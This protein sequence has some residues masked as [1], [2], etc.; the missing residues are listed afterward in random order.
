MAFVPKL[1]KA[2]RA[3]VINCTDIF[4]VR[5]IN[6]ICIFV[7]RRVAKI[8]TGTSFGIKFGGALKRFAGNVYWATPDSKVRNVG[9]GTCEKLIWGFCLSLLDCAVVDM[10]HVCYHVWPEAYGGL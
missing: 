6:I 9:F 5:E 10:G 1:V 3:N 8:E 4:S 2:G 7:P